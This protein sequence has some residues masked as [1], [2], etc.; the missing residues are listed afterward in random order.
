MIVYLD[1]NKW[2]QLARI[3]NGLDHSEADVS[4]LL[5]MKK[6]IELGYIFPL[7]AIH[8]MEFARIRDDERRR[9]LGRIMWK[10]SKGV[11][12]APP[13]KVVRKEIEV[14]LKALGYKVDIEEYNYIGNGVEHAFGE[15]IPWNI[16]Q[17]SSSLIVEALLC[18]F[19]DIPPIYGA[20]LKQRGN[21]NSYINELKSPD[22]PK[23]M[24]V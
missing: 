5:D 14:S 24:W 12:I 23:K 10:Y 7:S 3:E 20:S 8:Y 1:Q 11:S 6:A 18:G 13:H 9:R 22:F 16:D 4:I 2:I 17:K 21:F 19:S 15:L